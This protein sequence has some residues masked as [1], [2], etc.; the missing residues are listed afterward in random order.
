MDVRHSVA[1]PKYDADVNIIGGLNLYECCRKYNVRKVIF[2]STGGAIYGEQDT[3]PADEEHP[4]RPLSPYGISKLSN[5]KYL[6]YFKQ[7]WGLESVILRYANVYGPRQNPHGE[8]GVVAIFC[9]KMLSGKQPIINGD[10]KQTRDYVYVGDVV[11]AN[12]LAIQY[13][14][15]NVFNIGTGRETDVNTIFRI[16]RDNLSPTCAEQH[17]P[18]KAG[19][20][21]RSVISY[22]KTQTEL[23]WNPIVSLEEGLVKTAEFFRQKYTHK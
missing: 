4:Q 9:E 19:E 5:E 8:A 16:L 18:A 11:E 10:G 7:V 17:G 23:G 12:I 1:D 14:S 20:Q 2:A 3:F 13:S 22:S 15:S 21:L 6:Y